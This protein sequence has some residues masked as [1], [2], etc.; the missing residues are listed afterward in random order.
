MN[1]YLRYSLIIVFACFFI[2][3]FVKP[4]AAEGSNVVLEFFFSSGYCDSC[5]EKKPVVN[6]IETYYGDAIT[7]IRYPVDKTEYIDNYN[8]FINYGFK[9]YPAVVVKNTS[10]EKFN[11]LFPYE[12]ITFENLKDA[13]NY[14]LIG[15]YSK[16]APEPTGESTACSFGFCINASEFSLP[17]LAIVLGAL[18]SINPC[19][20]FILIFLLNLLL[21]VNS[22]RRMLLIGSIFIFFSGF[23]YFLIM[24]LLLTTF[25]AFEQ[26]VILAIFAG[27]I[28]LILGIINIKDFLFFKKGFS[29]SISD[30][31]KQKL[32]QRMR[33]I[34][35]VSYLPT[36]VFGTI[37]LAIFANTY[38]LACTLGFPVIF[39]NSLIINNVPLFESY[40]YIL[41]YNIV[42][43]IPLI[44]IVFIFVVT[45][46]RWKL[47]EYQGRTLKLISGVMMVSMGSVLL[48]KPD[49]LK[50]ALAAM[51]ILFLSIAIS[52]IVSFI[53]KKWVLKKTT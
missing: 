27:C 26:P 9:Y 5:E 42:Y 16:E 32:F 14:H 15:N 38:E 10:A 50:N 8:K 2:A 44:V 21:Y 19:S 52:M 34:V 53:W 48:L 6:D 3:S 49:L 40:I 51:C 45:F 17:V 37:V 4:V 18:D 7:V 33:G 31:K 11:L 13:V 20:F 1:K 41:L 22:R 36:M 23:I 25:T 24:V 35:R 47:S 28:A 43:V 12:D 29:L 46:G 30:D 39:T